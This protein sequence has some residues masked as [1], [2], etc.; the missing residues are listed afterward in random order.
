MAALRYFTFLKACNEAIKIVNINY[1]KLA[2]IYRFYQNHKK[3][4]TV[5]IKI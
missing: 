3:V 4:A 1:Q 2:N 5:E